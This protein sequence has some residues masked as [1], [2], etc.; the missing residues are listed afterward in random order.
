MTVAFGLIELAILLFIF[1]VAKAYFWW[2][3]RR[4]YSRQTGEYAE[5]KRQDAERKRQQDAV[6]RECL[7][8]VRADLE[9]LQRLRADV[10]ARLWAVRNKQ[11][12][13]MVN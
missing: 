11:P 9:N 8:E 4:W 6:I 10:D 7:D 5:W 3:D 1:A 13:A 2:S 12:N